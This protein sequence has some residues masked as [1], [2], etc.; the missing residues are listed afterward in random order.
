MALTKATFSVLTESST[1]DCGHGGK[2]DKTARSKLTVKGNGVLTIEDVDGKKIVDCKTP[3]QEGP[4]L[5]P[6]K[7][8]QEMFR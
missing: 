7:P 3:L 4:N 5:P 6:T 1:I 2:V 8:L